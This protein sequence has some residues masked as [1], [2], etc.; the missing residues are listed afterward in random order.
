LVSKKNKLLEEGIVE[1]Y[2]TPERP[3]V[4]MKDPDLWDKIHNSIEFEAAHAK[5]RKVIIKVRTIKHLRETL[6]EKYNTYLSRQCLSTYL[7]PRYQNTFTAR[8]HHHPA[9]VGLTSVVRIEMKSHVDE[10][11]CLASVKT[12]KV[13]AEVFADESIIIFQDDKTKIGL[14]IPAVGHTFKTIQIVN[15]SVIVENHDFLTGSKIKLI[16]S[17]YLL[18]NPADSS[19]TLRTGQL[20]IFIRP[21]Y[22]I[23]TRPRLLLR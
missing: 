6:K 18:I 13:F 16:P 5:R 10:H 17:I 9:K 7:E 8:R 3:S 22:F 1:K 15:E 12:A 14:E 19:D 23:R 20:S 21:E 2:D 11:Y 4:A